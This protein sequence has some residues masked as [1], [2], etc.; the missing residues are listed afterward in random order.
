M[1]VLKSLVL[2]SNWFSE[3]SNISLSESKSSMPAAVSNAKLSAPAISSTPVA[4]ATS[5]II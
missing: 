2:K 5:C 4:T 1:K 3:K